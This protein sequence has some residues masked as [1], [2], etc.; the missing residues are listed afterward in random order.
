MSQLISTPETLASTAADVQTIGSAINAA[1]AG[2]AGQ[3][4]GL[5]AAAED[6]VSAAIATLFGAYGQQYQ[7]TLSQAATFHTEFTRALAA[8]ASSY[9][10]AEAA[11]A[12]LVA[13]ISNEVTAPLRAMLGTTAL[14]GGASTGPSVLASMVTSPAGDPLY[15]LIMGG[16]NNPQPDPFYVNSVYNAYIKPA[17]GSAIVQ[18]LFTPEQFWPVTPNLGNMTFGQ[19]V[20][21]GVTLLNNA[22]YSTLNGQP[23][24]S[25]VV[26]GYSQSA[27]IA[28]NEI[29]NLM[30]AGSP[31]S[32]PGQLSFVLIGDPNNPVGGILERFPG[33]YIPF[34]DVAFNGATPPNSPYPTSIYTLQYDGIA[35]L[36]Q[37]PLNLVSDLNAF[38]GYFFVHGSY[39]DLTATQVAT[40]VQLPTSPDYTG[41]TKYYM[42]MSQN[43]PLLEPIRAIPYAGPPIADIF[44][45][46]LRVLVDLGYADYGPGANYANIPTPAGL[47]DIPNPFTVIPDLALGA[48]QGPYGAAVEIGV[49]SGLL[50]PSYFPNTYPWVPSINPGL[51]ISLGQSSTT[52]LSVLSGAAGNVLHLIPPPNFG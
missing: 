6:E 49:E 43:L 4:T 5:V 35:D 45:P 30:A 40:A 27:T 8:A 31:F 22:I 38:M 21:K 50:S 16:T 37:Y 10:Q 26:F 39:P 12:A 13:G 3:T 52:L 2:A 1:R 29:R 19:S 36:P 18:G 24:N 25:A 46:D 14:T 42:L 32:N 17:F 44:Q 9:A 28:T 20:A 7:A 23:N 33:F 48:V 34:L 15:A 41:S 11:N 51:N 47:F